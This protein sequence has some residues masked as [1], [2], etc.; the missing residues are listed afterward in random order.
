MFY[1]VINICK[2]EIKKR[3]IVKVKVKTPVINFENP[4]PV[5]FYDAMLRTLDPINQS[6]YQY[7]TSISIC[8]TIRS[9]IDLNISSH[10]PH[11]CFSQ[12]HWMTHKNDP[13]ECHFYRKSPSSIKCKFDLIAKTKKLKLFGSRYHCY[14][15]YHIV[16]HHKHLN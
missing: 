11:I 14:F 6:A 3:S 16:N 12:L 7:G 15:M 2:F 1:A 4:G 8:L 13:I 9:H 5:R 10:E